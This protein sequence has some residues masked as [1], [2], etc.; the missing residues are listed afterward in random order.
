MTLL[1]HG[2]EFLYKAVR[3]LQ[4]IQGPLQ[5]GSPLNTIRKN[6]YLQPRSRWGGGVSEWKIT[7]NTRAKGDS[8]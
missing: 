4:R 8:G 1:K 6:G 7:K 3:L 2:K 5:V